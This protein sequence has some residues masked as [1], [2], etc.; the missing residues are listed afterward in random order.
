MNLFQRF[1]YTVEADLHQLFD[2]KE[3]KKSDCDVK[4]IHS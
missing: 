4:S 1:R 2:K 3:Q